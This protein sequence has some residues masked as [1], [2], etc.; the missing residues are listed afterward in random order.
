MSVSDEEIMQAWAQAGLKPDY[1]SIDELLQYVE[2][3]RPVNPKKHRHKD[4]EATK[5]SIHTSGYKVPSL[6]W[7]NP[8]TGKVEVIIGSGRILAAA[9]DGLE[10]L[11]VHWDTTMTPA[12]AKALRLADNRT[13]EI[14]SAYDDRIII[15]TLKDLKHADLDLGYLKYDKYD[16]FLVEDLAADDPIFQ[17]IAPSYEESAN[18]LPVQRVDGCTSS[19][20]LLSLG[21]EEPP[22]RSVSKKEQEEDLRANLNAIYPSDNEYEIP[23]LLLNKQPKG[24][25]TPINRWGTQARSKRIDGGLIHFYTDD[26][27]FNGILN[28]PLIVLKTGCLSIVEPNFSTNDDMRRAIVL[29]YIYLKRYLARTWQE[30][31][32]DVWVDLAIAPRHRDLALIGVPIGYRCYATY[33]YTKDYDIEW[34]YKDFE[35]ALKHSQMDETNILFWVYGGNE[36]VQKICADHGWLWSAAH[37]RAYHHNLKKP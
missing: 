36:D 7:K 29:Y 3:T 25:D 35:Q 24:L 21:S 9:D 12:Q 15:D 5:G 33:T 20:Q 6:L 2:N 27:K 37:Q 31:G 14:S 30:H 26:Y 22:S 17:S 23:Q 32:L 10:A 1:L 34:I 16:K 13:P 11:P 19:V 4:I 28:N 18:G 8:Q